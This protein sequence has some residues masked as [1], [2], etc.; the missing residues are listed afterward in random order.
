MKKAS[1]ISF[2]WVLHSTKQCSS[3]R[4]ALQFFNMRSPEEFGTGHVQRGKEL[5]TP[6]S[7]HLIFA[8]PINWPPSLHV[9]KHAS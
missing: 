3:G 9:T 5:H 1:P 8:S 6:V 7:S 4:L 2:K